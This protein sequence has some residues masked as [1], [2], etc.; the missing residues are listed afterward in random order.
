V[1]DQPHCLT[2][3]V[4]DRG[5]GIAESELTR[6]FE[7]FYRLEGSRNPAT[8]GS[9]L[10]LSIARNLA[11]SMGGDVALRNRAGGGL[12]AVVTLPRG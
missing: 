9:G 3:I 4:R 2:L 8:G 6:V 12:E 11:Q 10:G 5:P 1:Q 7:P